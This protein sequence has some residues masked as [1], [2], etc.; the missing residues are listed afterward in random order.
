M[1]IIQTNRHTDAQRD[2]IFR[3]WNNEYPVQLA[4]DN[5]THLDDYFGD[6][7]GQAHFFAMDDGG[8]IIG[9]AFT[10]IRDDDQW[11]AIIVDGGQHKKGVGTL[12][13]KTLQ[14]T[15]PKLSGWVTDHDRYIKRDGMPYV[16]PVGFYMKNGF[17]LHTNIRLETERLSGA[18]ITWENSKG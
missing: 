10:F 18:K 7:S 4:F 12:L 14:L 6:L 1:H 17:T 15:V 9:W 16:S 8:D 2:A 5:M 3:L 13:I 11:F